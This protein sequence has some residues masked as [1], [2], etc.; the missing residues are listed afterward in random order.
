[1]SWNC[2][3]EAVVRKEICFCNSVSLASVKS[4][5][6]KHIIDLICML[7][8]CQQSC[9]YLQHIYCCDMQWPLFHCGGYSWGWSSSTGCSPGCNILPSAGTR[10]HW[11]HHKCKSGNNKRGVK[12][13]FCCFFKWNNFTWSLAHCY[14]RQEFPWKMWSYLQS[15]SA[16]RL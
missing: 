10:F 5:L 6:S 8:E 11:S 14:R 2:F 9:M 12:H 15:L 3:S 7:F 16:Y 4:W 13:L 1:M